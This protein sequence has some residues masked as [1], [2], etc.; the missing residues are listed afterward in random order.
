MGTLKEQ[1]PRDLV[2]VTYQDV[3]TRIDE[4]LQIAR[5]KDLS[6]EN[7]LGV[8]KL[9]E[10]DRKNTLSV[11]NGNILDEQLS[12]FGDLIEKLISVIEKNNTI[13]ESAPGVEL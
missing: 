13:I 3:S 12:G 8:Y 10:S 6:F 2:G 5:D 4:M 7:V 11:H 1:P 9:L